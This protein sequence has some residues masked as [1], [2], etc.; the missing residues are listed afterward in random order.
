MLKYV[1]ENFYLS[2]VLD[3][4]KIFSSQG[5]LAVR[6]SSAFSFDWTTVMLDFMYIVCN[7]H[8]FKLK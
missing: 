5:S 3:R 4:K 8:S 2:F 7:D 6:I 1:L